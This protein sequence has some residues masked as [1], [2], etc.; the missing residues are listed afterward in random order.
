MDDYDSAESYAKSGAVRGLM[1]A[2]PQLN[3]EAGTLGMEEA[4][5]T[6]GVGCCLHRDRVCLSAAP[7]PAG[8]PCGQG[9]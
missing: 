3:R 5:R 8:T 6:G 9:L 7:T 4:S 1:P 2:C